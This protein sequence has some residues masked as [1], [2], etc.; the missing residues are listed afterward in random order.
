MVLI[1][2]GTSSGAE[3]IA[4]ALVE[5]D[6]ASLVGEKSIG[7]G[8]VEE[9]FK[10]QNGWAVKL[11]VARFYSPKGHSLQGKGLMPDFQI[12]GEESFVGFKPNAERLRRDAQVQAARR[13]LALSLQHRR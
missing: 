1:D 3:I 6:R 11:S 2:E 12:P 5:N 10:L 4:S 8:S 13:L 9:I 7:K